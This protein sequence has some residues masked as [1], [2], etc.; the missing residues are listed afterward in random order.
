MSF[1]VRLAIGF[2]V[3]MTASCFALEQFAE[4]TG[5]ADFAPRHGLNDI[6]LSELFAW[7]KDTW[8]AKTEGSA[9]RRIGH[10]RWLR[11]VAVALGNAKT[12]KKYLRR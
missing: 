4:A 5:E 10:E 1:D 12:S 9:I 2:M 3:A 11:N 8:L 7:D 6:E